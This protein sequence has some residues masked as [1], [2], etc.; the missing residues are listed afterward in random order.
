MTTPS[1]LDVHHCPNSRAEGWDGALAWRMG[2]CA[3]WLAGEPLVPPA[4]GLVLGILLDN[5]WGIPFAAAGGLFLGAGGV[6]AWARQRDG[7]RHLAIALAALAVGA[8][9]H[10]VSFRH[11]PADHIVRY[12]GAEPVPVRLTATVVSPPMIR[13][14]TVGKVSWFSES[15]R[16]RFLVVAEKI[17]GTEGDIPVGGAVAVHTREPL[18][19]VFPGDRV[20]L[21]GRMYRPGPPENP[22]GPDH[23]LTAQRYGVLVEML[24][25]HAANVTVQ[26]RR[27]DWHRW[28][29][30]VRQRV[31]TALLDPTFPGDV[32]GSQLLAALVLG[33][34]SAVDEDLNEAFIRTGTV[35]YLSVSGAHV[36][37]LASV[38]WLVSALFGISHRMCAAWVIVLVTAYAGLAES[39]PPIIRAAVMA[40][41]Y[42]LA[43]LL[44]RPIRMANWLALSLL[45]LLPVQPTQL[46]GVGF[47]MSYITLVVFIYCG[48]QLH[49]AGSRM[50]RRL[51]KRD[52]PLLMPDVQRRLHPSRARDVRR[53]L[54]AVVGA[55]IAFSIA[56]WLAGVLLS[57]YYFRQFSLWG[58]FNSVLIVPLV[59]LTL[60][61][62]LA[63]TV[64]S[65]VAPLAAP[66]L[67]WVLAAMTK[68]LIAVVYALAKLPGSS[69]L[70]PEVGNGLLL[71]GLAVC[72]L[73]IVRPGLKISG[74]WVAIA[75]LGFAVL[76]SWRLAPGRP[77]DTLHVHILAVGSG[78]TAVIQL[79]NGKTL[80]YDL[81]SS[82]TFNVE[83]T[84]LGP[85]L[86]R[87]RIYG[88][89][90]VVLSHFD[91]DH[92]GGMPD[93]LDRRR[94]EAVM[95][96]PHS[97]RFAPPQSGAGRVLADVKQRGIPWQ[98][99]VRGNRLT[100][101]GDV[102]VE[103]LW[104]PP[105]EL[106][107]RAESNDFSVVLRITCAGRR[108][109]FCSDIGPHPQRELIAST[110]LGADVLILPH[111]GAVKDSTAAF[112]AAVNPRYCIR[113][114]G[115]PDA[116][117][118]NGLLQL[119]AGRQ[120]YNTA[121]DGAIRIE[122]TP[123]QLV[124]HPWLKRSGRE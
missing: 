70:T 73:A 19:A 60:V 117:T 103:V 105:G 47:Q 111:H 2:V 52:D 23:A 89:A 82:P 107:P 86:A 31:R 28:L 110:D 12:C 100:G 42:C 39:S 16:S 55:S 114:S 119:V 9:L 56:A 1:S 6:I 97:E 122:V 57:A 92:Y 62:G 10:D 15:P 34:R 109:L 30:W 81:G 90:A 44:R 67:G 4:L 59:W 37:M 124:V 61:L 41:L 26:A 116:A 96:A 45:V 95:T 71:A 121:D 102:V 18:V 5:A 94:V 20:E 77:T 11:W 24:C 22:G 46:F 43:I 40:D 108:L 66:A 29:A 64:V 123:R 50:I 88:I 51:L 21:F 78:T 14:K 101:T 76:A 65:V 8:A 93:L 63:Q 48:P 68:T 17:E 113:S 80:L 53:W 79:P 83:R 72:G 84:V 75:G 106:P 13:R 33:Q 54:V 58:W 115:R 91:L 118:D 69:V 112:I 35:H 7:L 99:V 25:E 104:P 36:G 98:T 85:V 32:P 27:S 74:H 87:E 49:R 120:Y 3:A 38:V